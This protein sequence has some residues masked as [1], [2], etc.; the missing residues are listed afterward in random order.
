M[1]NES[2]NAHK[3]SNTKVIQV[4]QSEA[5]RGG[6]KRQ[7][8]AYTR[9]VARHPEGW[10]K[11]ANAAER[12]LILDHVLTRFLDDERLKDIAEDLGTSR[13]A[14]NRAI[15]KHR[16]D[17]W[18]DIQVARAMSALER[19]KD[20]LEMA[21]PAQV[22]RAREL[23]KSAQ[24]ELERLCRRLYGQDAPKDPASGVSITLNIG[25][26]AHAKGNN[27]IDQ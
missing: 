6:I 16:P 4:R 7:L 5:V 23:L 17:E 10:L 25:G 13:S 22:P 11:D 27:V 21:E 20:E 12:Q 24:W 2:S 9:R 19:A 15:L 8:S 14:L 18:Q 1:D 26:F 3:D